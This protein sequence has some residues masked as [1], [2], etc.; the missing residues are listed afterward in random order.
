MYLYDS[1]PQYSYIQ[2]I[3]CPDMLSVYLQILYNASYKIYESGHALL[4]SGVFDLSL[5]PKG[6]ENTNIL[7]MFFLHVFTVT[8]KQW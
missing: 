2:H 3:L 6:P 7:N 8:Q 4:L 1:I 5:L